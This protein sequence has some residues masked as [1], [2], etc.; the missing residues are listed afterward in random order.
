MC[1]MHLSVVVLHCNSVPALHIVMK[2]ASLAYGKMFFSEAVE[3][4]K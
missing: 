3:A 4:E 1:G 2:T